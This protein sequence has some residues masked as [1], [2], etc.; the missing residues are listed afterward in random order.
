M[1]PELLIII[2]V[3]IPLFVLI[4]C[5]LKINGKVKLEDNRYMFF[6]VRDDLIMLV[7]KGYLKESDFLFQRYYK[8]S[9]LIVNNT[10]L[11]TFKILVQN[12]AEVDSG[13][14]DIKAILKELKGKDQ[15]VKNVILEF[16]TT[17]LVSIRRNS[18]VV[19]LIAKCIFPF[20]RTIESINYL[21]SAINKNHHNRYVEGTKV[22]WKSQ[23]SI[24]HL[25]A[26]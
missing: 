17:V 9:N 15:E 23:N 26:F 20:I 7:A 12:L 1:T 14:S 13:D 4:V 5:L 24:N 16:Y 21:A 3:T 22:A 6:K 25:M 10:H 8:F 18:L 19:S 2:F 11:L